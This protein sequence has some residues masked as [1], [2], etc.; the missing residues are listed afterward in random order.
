MLIFEYLSWHFFEMP[1]IILGAWKNYLKFGNYFFSITLL[2]K[3]L[4]S[5][6]KRITWS[7]GKGFSPTRYFQVWFSNLFSR[8]VGLVLRSVLIVIGL[9]FEIIILILGGIFYIFWI[10]L[11]AII[12]SFLVFGIRLIF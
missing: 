6:W 11:P 1:K 3:S 7:Y 2:L 5:P 10:F 9:A 12:I 4:F 8:T